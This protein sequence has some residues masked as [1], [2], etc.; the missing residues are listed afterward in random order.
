MTT[1][2]DGFTRTIVRLTTENT[3]LREENERMKRAARSPGLAIHLPITVRIT[4]R[5][6]TS[7]QHDEPHF[8]VAAALISA[9]N[10]CMCAPQSVALVNA[11]GSELV[12]FPR[13]A[14]PNTALVAELRSR[15]AEL[16]TARARIAELE[17][18]V[19]AR[20]A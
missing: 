5:D 17:A 20:A 3:V 6:G 4:E 1:N 16:R 10:A 2:P 13:L 14:H 15:E 7:R 18:E 11:D 8:S 9:L 12:G 19:K